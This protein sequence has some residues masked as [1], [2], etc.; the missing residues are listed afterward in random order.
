MKIQYKNNLNPIKIRISQNLI[1]ENNNNIIY[2]QF[3]NILYLEIF[4]CLVLGLGFVEKSQFSLVS[5]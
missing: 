2:R 5:V 3:E 1:F 4:K